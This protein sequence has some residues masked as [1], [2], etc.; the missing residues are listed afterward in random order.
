MAEQTRA[1]LH[2]R[3]LHRQILQAYDGLYDECDKAG[4]FEEADEW[5][6]K[7]MDEQNIIDKLDELIRKA[8]IEE[9]R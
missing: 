5:F 4:K 1:L 9:R 3:E 8:W 2:I 6:R 7:G